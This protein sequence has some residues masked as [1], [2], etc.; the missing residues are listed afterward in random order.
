[1]Y[2]RQVN[3]PLLIAQNGDNVK[4]PNN[5]L[6]DDVRFYNRVISDE[7]ASE[8]Y[9]NLSVSSTE[10]LILSSSSISNSYGASLTFN[11]NGSIDELDILQNQINYLSNVDTNTTYTAGTGINIVGNEISCSVVDTNTT[12]TAGTGINIVGN[13][14]S[15]SVVDTNTTYTAGT[16]MQLTGTTFNCTVTDTTYT[17]GTGISISSTNE[18]SVTGGGGS[19]YWNNNINNINYGNVIVSTSNISIFEKTDETPSKLLCWYKFNSG[20]FLSDSSGNNLTLTNSGVVEDSDAQ[21]GDKAAYFGGDDYLYVAPPS[22]SP[23]YFNRTVFSVAFWYKFPN[24]DG[25]PQWRTLLSA[26]NAYST[27]WA[28]YITTGHDSSGD[29]N[30]E[31]WSLTGSG[32]EKFQTNIKIINTWTHIVF[33][34]NNGSMQCYKNNETPLIGNVSPQNIQNNTLRIGAV[35][36]DNS[37]NP[38]DGS[39]LDDVRIY[40]K[41]LTAAEVSEIY[42]GGFS[43]TLEAD[44][45]TS[46]KG[47]KIVFN[48]N[49]ISTNN[50][51][52]CTSINTNHNGINIGT[53]LFEADFNS[54]S[55]SVGHISTNSINT[56]GKSITCGSINA[57]GNSIN[58]TNV[59]VSG[60]MN[61]LGTLYSSGNITCGNNQS[62]RTDY[63]KS[64]TIGGAIFIGS[65]VTIWDSH[66]STYTMG[67]NYTQFGGIN[68][69]YVPSGTRAVVCFRATADMWLTNS[70]A[71]V[72]SSDERIKRDIVDINDS[73]A[74]DKILSI[75]PKKYKYKDYLSK[76]EKEVYGF[77]SQDIRKYIP[78]AVSIQKE[79]IPNI[80]TSNIIDETNIITL[81]P[82][83]FDS[84][85]T[86]NIRIHYEDGEKQ[87]LTYEIISSNIDGI[88]IKFDS[89]LM[90]DKGSN[91]F[92]FG[93]EVDDFHVLDKTYIFTLN[94]CAI[95]E[96]HKKNQN[97]EARLSA[98]E[99]IINNP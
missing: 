91:I 26:R 28:I 6:L 8:I 72:W 18:I 89:N 83:F 52:S 63:I 29:N 92:V 12:Y 96:L 62:V 13:E 24:N 44:N 77:I 25:N 32:H 9:S 80:Y 88:N 37:Y 61:V 87:E 30:L 54:S 21:E 74:L 19:S 84:N 76:G 68:Y 53:A 7:E 27:G 66:T 10:N 99:A 3:T 35:D 43:L 49:L 58:C 78:E 20:S 45:I 56:N 15:C 93:T 22:T 95:Q 50:P 5:T 59:E 79:I 67:Y 69:G 11:L 81:S 57:N 86:S 65:Y 71:I 1:M 16:G 34:Y 46:S 47:S 70:A 36:S 31:F 33:T 48:D 51:I 60:N 98:L 41:K 73:S 90:H 75:S 17:A 23:N 4:L 55:L 2:K 82:S 94:V 85:I 40:D 64:A 38:P 97:L 39:R 42:L 14:I